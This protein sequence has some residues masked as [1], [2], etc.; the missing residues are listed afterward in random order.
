MEGILEKDGIDV[1]DYGRPEFTAQIKKDI[2]DSTHYLKTVR[3][4]Q[5]SVFAG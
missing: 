2:E 1:V 5:V 3:P 4:D